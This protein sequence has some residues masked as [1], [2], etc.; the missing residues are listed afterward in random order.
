MY[1]LENLQIQVAP[2]AICKTCPSSTGPLS[3]GQC[4]WNHIKRKMEKVE[5]KRRIVLNGGR[6]RTE[7]KKLKKQDWSTSTY[8]AEVP[9][10]ML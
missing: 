10:E 9:E 6:E 3:F 1:I 2:G 5:T 4:D 8:S 7:L